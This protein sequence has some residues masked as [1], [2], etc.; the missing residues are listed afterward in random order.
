MCELKK[1][2]RRGANSST[3]RSDVERRFDVSDGVREREGDL[4]RG[5][6]TGFA[7]VIAGD[8]DRIP[9]RDF[10]RAESERVGD[11]SQ[12][13]LRRIDVGA[14]R[15]VLLEDIVLDRAVDFVERD[16]LLSR[17]GEIETKQESRPSR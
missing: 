12:A 1:K 4:L 17:D 15:D 8:R 3:L 2:E 16:I 7:D 13:R 11:Q 5:G 6:R 14:A 10:A 9:V